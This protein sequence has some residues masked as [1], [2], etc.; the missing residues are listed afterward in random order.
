MTRTTRTIG[1]ALALLCVIGT[2]Y[3][4]FTAPYVRFPGVRLGGELTAAPAD[5]TQINGETVAQLK[6]AGFPPFVINV[7]YVGTPDG[8]ITASRPDNG[9]WANRARS[10]PDGWLRIGDRSYAMSSREI[11]GEA[12]IPFLEQYGSKYNMPMR[13]DF[14]GEIIPG[15]NEPLHTW[16]V[17]FWTAR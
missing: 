8:I 16:E 9:Y 12:R 7:W 17:F 6:L 5:W 15:T 14:E 1:L 4:V 11:L 3:Y 2:T 10:N 13:Y